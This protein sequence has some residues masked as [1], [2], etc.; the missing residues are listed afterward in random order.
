MARNRVIYQSEALFVGPTGSATGDIKQLSRVQS[1]NYS[2]NITRQDVNQFGN[3]AAI[4]RL[5]LEQPTVSLDFTYYANTGANEA[6]LGLYVNP[7]NTSAGSL[8]GA[9]ANIM[10]NINDV[11][12]YYIL[13]SPE[14]TDAN[15]DPAATGA[16]GKV[17]GI[18]NGFMSS[19]SFE[20]AVGAFPTNTVNVE[21]YNMRFYDA[22][23]GNIPTVS[24]QDG[25]N[26]TGQFAIPAP[27][28]GQGYSALKPGDITFNVSGDVGLVA[29]D[30]KPQ[31]VTI[32]FDITREDLQK[33]GN[34]FAYAKVITFPLT[35][36]MTVDAVLGDIEA[37]NLAT[38]V[39]GDCSKYDLDVT[40]N[41]AACGGTAKRAI[42]Y[43]FKGAKLDSQ[44]FT[45]SIGAN[46]AVTLTFSTQIG[47]P[48]DNLNGVFIEG[49]DQS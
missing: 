27:S 36:T 38:L 29:T 1:C 45:S 49:G 31:N 34:R 40:I 46:K 33:L 23:T 12:N 32:S 3:L 22:T 48:T 28:T 10:R 25:S 2:F 43:T 16:N 44:E 14:G 15:T 5:I 30:L 41:G 26:L 20:A 6:N 35:A 19:Y 42:K 24:Q 8:T 9:L 18:G 39:N 47:G 4:D 11:R 37:D 21:G 13:V 17:I 7:N